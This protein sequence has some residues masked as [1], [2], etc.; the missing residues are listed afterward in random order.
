MDQ[1]RSW[2]NL[3]EN[4][5]YKDQF[6][7]NPNYKWSWKNTA[8]QEKKIQNHPCYPHSERTNVCILV[9]IMQAVLHLLFCMY[10]GEL[11]F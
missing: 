9:T 10:I 8:E 11:I 6:R 4:K 3:E 7:T 2:V 5:N 1:K